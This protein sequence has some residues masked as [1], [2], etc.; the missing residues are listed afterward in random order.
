MH[1]KDVCARAFAK[2][3]TRVRE[4]RLPCPACFRLREGARAFSPYEVDLMPARPPRSFRVHG[5][6][7]AV[8]VSGQV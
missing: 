1:H 8:S 2:L 3:A 6:V 7:T 4:D 5:T